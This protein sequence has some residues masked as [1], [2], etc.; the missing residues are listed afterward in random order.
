[1]LENIL[2]DYFNLPE[3]YEDYEW[4]KSYD[5]LIN[6]LYDLEELGVLDNANSVVDELD[7]IDNEN[8]SYVEEDSKLPWERY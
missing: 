3:D 8:L 5:K 6:L 4:N 7:K 1:M 2:I